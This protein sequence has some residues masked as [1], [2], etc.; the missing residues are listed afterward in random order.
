[1]ELAEGFIICNPSMKEKILK[2]ENVI[3]NYIFLTQE[4]LEKRLTFSLRPNAIFQLMKH[5]GFSYSLALEYANAVSKLEDKSYSNPK[6]DSIVSVFRYL[7]ENHLVEEDALF[8]FRLKQFPVTFIDPQPTLEYQSL[9]KLTEQYTKV[10]EVYPQDKNYTPLVYEFKTILEES[11]FVMNQIK[12]LLRKGISLKDIYIVNV[13]EEYSFLLKRLSK[14]YGIPLEF[15]GYRN[16]L[17]ASFI[18][19]F[20]DKC[21]TNHSFQSILDQLDSKNILYPVLVDVLNENE[22]LNERPLDCIEFLKAVLKNK[23]YPQ[24]KYMEAVRFEKEAVLFDETDYVFYVGFNL[25]SAPKIRKE[26]GFL[27]DKELS[28]LKKSTSYDKN[29]IE[30]KRLKNWILSTPHLTLTYKRFVKTESYFPSLLIED[31]RLEVIKNPKLPFG[32]AK[33]EDELRLVGLY[34]LYLKYGQWHED[35][36]EYGIAEAQYKSYDHSYKPLSLETMQKH[37]EDKPLRL[38]YS[39]VKL[40][41]ACPFSYYADRILGLNEFKPQMAARMGTFSHAV[42][43][44]SYTTDFN[45][46]ESVAKHKA[47]NAIESKDEFFFEQMTSVLRNLL[48]F[49]QKHEQMSQLKTIEREAHIEVIKDTYTFEGYIDKLMYMIQN[50]EVFA[51]I[52]DYKTGADIVS[53]DNIEDGFHLQLPSYMYLLSKYPPFAGLKLHIIG[54]YLQKV[55]I[56][57]FDHKSDVEA[58]MAK[59]FMLEG[60]SVANPR[61]LSMLDPTYEKSTYIKSLGIGKDGFLRYSKVFLESQQE[62]IISMVE[63]LL[64]QASASIHDG[65]FPI[66]PKKI[67]GKNVSCTFC[68]Y[69]DICFYEYEDL[70]ELS[71]K[72][73]GKGGDANGMD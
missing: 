71:H 12:E 58:Q 14:S 44:D 56:V 55:N 69:K 53:L 2:E 45:F 31:L 7:K 22:L 11:L 4:E 17:S 27:N 8:L 26:E 1:M 35:L 30:Y 52:V 42:L 60:Y 73:F 5:Y 16:L 57:I 62:E 24:K 68:K 6:L 65:V 63:G 13:D 19:Q 38:A 28:L 32:Y 33:L 47:E 41:F 20:L 61:L 18:K 48:D 34:D 46:L 9:K 59:K 37:F 51:A 67:N 50:D 3:K 39:N 43:E 49:N 72:P 64:D 40:Y 54:L 10:Y 25:V 21:M 66:E 23:K 15:E 29:E 70:K 36:E